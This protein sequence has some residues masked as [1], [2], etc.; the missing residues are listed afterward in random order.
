MVTAGNKIESFSITLILVTTSKLKKFIKFVT[1]T[2]F[3]KCLEIH[4]LSLTRSILLS[5]QLI[6]NLR[7]LHHQ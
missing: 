7:K 6:K 2:W 5:I 1:K 4:A 3:E